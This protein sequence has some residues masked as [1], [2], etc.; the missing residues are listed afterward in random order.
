[1]IQLMLEQPGEQFIGLDG[2]LVSVQVVTGEVDFLWPNDLPEQAGDRKTTLFV[3]PLTAGLGDNRVDDGLRAF[4]DVIHKQPSLHPNLGCCKADAGFCVHRVQHVVDK[5]D[6]LAVNVGDLLSN[7]TEDWVT[8]NPDLIWRGHIHSGYRRNYRLRSVGTTATAVDEASQNSLGT[9]VWCEVRP[10]QRQETRRS[11]ARPLTCQVVTPGQDQEQYFDADPST[12]SD[13]ASVELVLPDLSA[14]LTTDSG[15]FAKLRIDAGSKL[16]LLDGPA[17]TPGDQHLLD[18]GA[19]Y[20]PIAIALA[21]RNPEAT[22]WA[23]EINSR[24]RELCTAN[25]AAA[26]LSNVRVA[27]P[28]EVPDDV[29]FDR[30]W[31]NPPIRI[32]KS[33]LQQLLTRWLDRLADN[34][35]A[36]LVVQKHLGS[37]SLHRWLEQS[38]WST[39]RRSSRAGYRLL[40]VKARTDIPEMPSSQRSNDE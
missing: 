31:S 12:P 13:P 25:A 33:A 8:K 18:L 39:T 16:L 27:A 11:V 9:P 2:N 4:T 6:Q 34:G 7:L 20:G 30:L 32:G 19:G 10:E 38:G 1:M 29:R 26:G 36:H 17:P 35:S 28:E 14:T 3:C 22:V 37:D 23:V 24:A 15:V 5:L 40:D 21:V